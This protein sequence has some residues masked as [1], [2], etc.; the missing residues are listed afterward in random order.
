[1][2]L[3]QIPKLSKPYRKKQKDFLMI[4]DLPI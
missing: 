2:K 3:V 1:L 4:D